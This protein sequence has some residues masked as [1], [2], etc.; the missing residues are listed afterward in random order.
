MTDIEN[1]ENCDDISLQT[2]KEKYFWI[3]RKLIISQQEQINK[4]EY[5][6]AEFMG[7]VEY[8]KEGE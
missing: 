8:D 3:M 7:K 4:L 2:F 6:V 1:L 5:E